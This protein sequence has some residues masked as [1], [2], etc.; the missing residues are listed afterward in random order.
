MISIRFFS[1]KTGFFLPFDSRFVEASSPWLVGQDEHRGTLGTTCAELDWFCS[2]YRVRIVGRLTITVLYFAA[3]RELVGQGEASLTL[4]RGIETL[5]QLAG[6]L[7]KLV[8]ALQG[9]LGAVRWARN[10]ELVGLDAALTDG[11]VIAI[12]PPVAGG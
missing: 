12:I 11:D 5:R 3:V 4:P 6:H 7:E 10:E 8:P 1:L 2:G 9:R